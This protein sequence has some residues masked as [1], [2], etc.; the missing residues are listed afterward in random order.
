M[1]H[2][3]RMCRAVRRAFEE[4]EALRSS[5]DTTGIQIL[6]AARKHRRLQRQRDELSRLLSEELSIG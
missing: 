2:Y 3:E 1:D 4:L 6:R 5:F